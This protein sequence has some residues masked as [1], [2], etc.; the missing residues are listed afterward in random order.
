MGR[1]RSQ[2]AIMDLSSPDIR[3]KLILGLAGYRFRRRNNWDRRDP[4]FRATILL[5]TW[6]RLNILLYLSRM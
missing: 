5:V 4:V 1:I 3:Q 6:S 2:A